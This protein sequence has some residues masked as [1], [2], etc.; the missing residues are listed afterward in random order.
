MERKLLTSRATPC[1]APARCW[2]RSAAPPPSVRAAEFA[3]AQGTGP[4]PVHRAPAP[5]RA[6]RA[7]VAFL[8]VAV[9]KPHLVG[10]PL[11]GL[12]RGNPHAARLLAERVGRV[13]ARRRAR[14]AFLRMLRH[15]R[16]LGCWLTVSKKQMAT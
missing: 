5:S 4:A 3:P 8:A 16:L 11:G 1:P 15:A 6:S 9:S 10:V 13:G 7:W 12:L 14:G 2:P